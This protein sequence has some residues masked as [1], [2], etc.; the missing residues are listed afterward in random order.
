[1]STDISNDRAWLQPVGKGSVEM[2][3]GRIETMP[4]GPFHALSDE[5]ATLGESPVYSASDDAVWWVDITGRK[6]IRTCLG[7]ETTTWPTPEIPGFVQIDR[8]ARPIVGMERGIFRF[9]A[10]TGSFIQ[11][12]SCP[13]IGVRFNDSCVDENGTLWAGTMDLANREPVGVLYRARDDGPLVPVLDGFVTINGLAVDERR[14]RLYVSDSH[15]SVQTVWVFD[16]SDDG[17]TPKNRR[18]FARFDGLPGRPDGAAID[19]KG[20]YWIA[21]ISGGK[22]YGFAPD[23]RMTGCIPVPFAAPTKLAFIGREGAT[24]AVTSLRDDDH[25]GHLVACAADALCV[26]GTPQNHCNIGAPAGSAA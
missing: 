12:L 20:G 22:L 8:E 11:I 15:P 23:G 21:G 26:T 2:A 6:L 5:P 14:R 13:Q 3:R 18:I 10:L 7:G 17:L 9:D 24:V 16:I 19:N 4:A 1:M 25:D